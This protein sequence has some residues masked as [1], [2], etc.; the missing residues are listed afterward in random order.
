MDFFRVTHLGIKKPRDWVVAYAACLVQ[1]PEDVASV[2][3]MG[4]DDGCALWIDGKVIGKVHK[5]RG[6]KV[7]EDKYSVPLSRGLHRI[8][9]KVDNH[10]SSFEFALK[11]LTADGRAIPGMRIWN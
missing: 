6:M 2:V 11:L 3:L 5:Q 1:V 10:A 4:S 9:V 7:D 8:L